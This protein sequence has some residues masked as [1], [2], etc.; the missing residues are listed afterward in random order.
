METEVSSSLAALEGV[1]YTKIPDI[2][3]YS[4]DTFRASIPRP[5]DYVAL[6]NGVFVGIECKQS[7]NPT[8]LPLSN[9]KDHQVEAILN[10]EKCGGLGYLLVNVRI[11]KS[12]PRSNR[13]FAMTADEVNYWCNEQDER[14][15]IPVPW[16]K[17][18]QEWGM[19]EE[20]IEVN[21]VKIPNS[22]KYGWDLRILSPFTDS[23][24]ERG[25]E[26]RLL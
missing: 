23:E 14:E 7:R 5:F 10:V 2:P 3:R 25:D 13:M 6:C 20:I 16:S 15:S 21:R 8:S 24:F 11:T 26:P 19:N 12:S 4:G 22:D 9:I 1:W 18:G 17:T